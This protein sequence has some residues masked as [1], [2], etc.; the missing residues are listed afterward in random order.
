MHS[1]KNRDLGP[2]SEP[3]AII[4]IGCRFP[5][6]NGQDE[7][8]R[9]LRD[10]IDAITDIPSGRFEVDSVYD[11]LPGAPGKIINRAGGFLKHIDQFDP[12]FFG[13]SP[14][15]ALRLDPQQ[16]LLLEVTWE[17]LED[18]GIKA[19]ALAGTDTCVFIGACTSDYEDIQYHL[20]DRSEIDF[21]VATGTARSLLSGRISYTFDLRGPSLTVDTACSSSLVAVHLAC[22]SLCRGESDLAIAGGVNLVLLPE[23]SMP[24]SRARMLAA[25]SRC[26]FGDAS[27]SGFTRSDGVG[28]VLLKP[29]SKAKADQDPIYAVILSTAT[30]N[31]GRSSGLLATPSRDGQRAVLREAYRKAGISPGTV[32]YVEVHGTGT[33]VGDP[34]E[35]Q[36]LGAV[37]AEGRPA[38]SPCILGSV[39]TNIGHAE[40]AAGIA[41]LIKTAL[42]LKH[43]AIPPS[44]HFKNPNP[45]IPW[46]EL[47][48]VV[49]RELIPWPT[50]RGPAVA[51][52]SAFGLSA[53]NSHI[54]LQEA[55]ESHAC[56]P[57]GSDSDRRAHVLT[58]SAH[59]PMAL[60]A[61]AEAYAAFS[62]VSR[63]ALRDIC[64]SASVR[65]THH[66]YRLAVAVCSREELGDDL[67]AF[68]DKEVRP[69]LAWS[70]KSPDSERKLVFVFPGQGSQWLGMGCQL[71]QQ[72]LVFRSAL[73][74]CDE[75]FRRYVD[76]SLIQQLTAEPGKSR[77]SEIDFVQPCLF[78]IQVA[79]AHLW[80]HWGIEPNAV[81]GQSMGE[82]AAAHVA[83][84]LSLDDAA[85]II[86]RRSSLLKRMSGRGGMAVIGLSF[87]ESQ[88]ALAGY[89]D[90]LSIAVSSGATSTVIAGN[91][92]AL[93]EVAQALQRRGVFCQEVKVDVASHSPQ[94]DPLR[95]D[96]LEALGGINPKAGHIPI[97]ST[98][99]GDAAGDVILDA[100]YWTANLRKPV[101]FSKAVQR[102]I[103]NGHNIFLELSPHPILSSPIQQALRQLGREARVLPSL[104]HDEDERTV[105]LGSLGA[106]YA[107]G[108]PVEWGSLY[109]E[110][111]HLVNLPAYKWQRE[112]FWRGPELSAN[113]RLKKAPDHLL[114]VTGLQSAAD[115]ETYFWEFDLSSEMFPFLKDHCI[116][117]VAVLP[118][119]AYLEMA[120][121][122]GRSLFVDANL[123]LERV[124][125]K[126]VLMLSEE[127][128]RIQLVI[129]S[130]TSGQARFEFFVLEPGQDRHSWTLHATGSMRS[131]Q[132]G[133]AP[134]PVSTEQIKNRSNHLLSKT[135][136]YEWLAE[137]GLEYG[138]CFQGVEEVWTGDK[139]ALATIVL[140]RP[141]ADNAGN[142]H[143]HPA[144]LDSCFQVLAATL[145]TAQSQTYVPVGLGSLRIYKRPGQIVHAYALLQDCTDKTAELLKGDLLVLDEDEQVLLEV[146]GMRMKR[147]D[148]E[149]P[150]SREKR[151]VEGLL[152]KIEWLSSNRSERT[153]DPQDQPGAWVVFI[154]KGGVGT[155]L[156]KCLESS[157]EH[158]VK[159]S[160][161]EYYAK[162]GPAHYQINAGCTQDYAQLFSDVFI[163]QTQRC[164]G[165]VNLWSID[166]AEPGELSLD[167]A[168]NSHGLGWGSALHSVKAL[169]ELVPSHTP[170]LWL[171]TRGVQPVTGY[172]SLSPAQSPIWGLGRAIARE[173]PALRCSLVDLCNAFEQEAISL[174]RELSADGPEDQVAL[175]GD[176][177]YV[178]RLVPYD[179]PDPTHSERVDAP[180]DQPFRL[181]TTIPG[182]LDSLTLRETTRE[183]PGSGDIEI[184]IHAVGLN[185]RDVMLAM[186]VLPSAP[187]VKED[188]GW[189]CAGRVVGIGEGVEGFAIGDDVFAIAHPCFGAYAKTHA[190]LAL[191]KPAHL[192][193]EE[194]ATIPLT[195]LT[196][197]YSL[198]HL[199]NLQEGERVLIHSASGGVGLAAVRIAQQKGADIFAT[200]GSEQKRAF[201][202]SLGIRHVFSSRSLDFVDEIME[203][204]NGEGVDI[205]LNSLTGEAISAGL[206]ILRPG[207]RFM[208]LGRR[209][210]YQGAKL[211]LEPFRKSLSFFAIDLALL[212]RNNP[213]WAGSLLHEAITCF[214]KSTSSP[215]P[216]QLFSMANVADGFRSMA[217]AR[218][219]GKIALLVHGERIKVAPSGKKEFKLRSD[220]TYLITGGLGAL[221]L[222]IARWMIERG[223]RHLVLVARSDGSPSAREAVETM[224]EAAEV[225]VARADVSR[226]KE[227]NR[228]LAHINDCMPPLRGLVHAAGLLDDGILVQQ[229]CSRFNRVMAPKIAGAW[230]LH[231][232]TLNSPLDFFVLF[233]SV[234]ALLGSAGQGNY[235]AA[236]AFLDCLAHYRRS[237]GMPG[238]S[239]NWGPWAEIGLAAKD[240]LGQRLAQK[241]IDSITP[242]EGVSAFERLLRASTAQASVMSFDLEQW[243]RYYPGAASSPFFAEMA[244]SLGT[245]KPA[246]EGKEG[247]VTREALLNA[248]RSER[249]DL[250]QRYLNNLLARVLGFDKTALSRLDP[251]QPIYRFGIDSLMALEVKSR[252]EA[253]LG[254]VIPIV[255][256]L[257]GASIAQM[258]AYALE[259]L[260]ALAPLV[261]CR[262]TK[263]GI[264]VV[265]QWEELS[266]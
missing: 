142:Y 150:E 259:Q 159:V 115:P 143:I 233:S 195:W 18:A 32:Q 98:V 146:R 261:E 155:T 206:S 117:G 114:S 92:E 152:Y 99:I 27:A 100:E 96:L 16:R 158:C 265:E 4:G 72:E 221:G 197:H 212:I 103:E 203:I 181:E 251:N 164:R 38:N 227:V 250:L 248:Q 15:E 45:E 148:Q 134:A 135:L 67:Q 93:L 200:A 80:Q 140:P 234:A 224:R 194:A 34:V 77:L 226:H 170:R 173:H 42:C 161:G 53:T 60:E 186:D 165:V 129:S 83:G 174:W 232:L 29:L 101:L 74:R 84:A 151:R 153:R 79:L 43:K 139:E 106:L 253:D 7:F 166:A 205:V 133:P 217:Q 39:K 175:Q 196:A 73:V 245:M 11:P 216:L 207:G 198:N 177:R 110:G 260:P 230:N 71:M 222:S 59:S 183:K 90:R 263:A 113:D 33:S 26:K 149:R 213:A 189:E 136:Y 249:T 239:I 128:S 162:V 112:H 235:S 242:S 116:Q 10:G 201:L 51:A 20:R 210:I 21:Y 219:I 111:G 244:R 8:W 218:H 168:E 127:T 241:G 63:A 24:F 257:K 86:C 55:P 137:R 176:A 123:I 156:V 23:L 160:A 199:G 187:D 41:G 9:L 184:R 50:G 95:E 228:V 5:G 124:D 31:D 188:F 179:A 17:A 46:H 256:L 54:V 258:T 204:T 119:A 193:F 243:N 30:N 264:G 225:L 85:R 28:V 66:D 12:Y 62:R 191:H 104:R 52:V 252:I 214:E 147:V 266:L 254:I 82:I 58:L 75:A 120:I 13:I 35:V 215:L 209:D 36:S 154:D 2:E 94:M 130:Q 56:T 1:G 70:Q 208:E 178:A 37:L 3:V 102:L 167:L 78:A 69:S 138:P 48:L 76:W 61:M 144:L 49:S 122:A 40:G 105:M 65:R 6:A 237:Q 157:G 169:E 141:V 91:T 163:S 229:D 172:E 240:D 220:G 202:K 89:E 118:A 255:N 121:V 25:D 88:T 109:A 107:A 47:P 182:I 64:Y 171:V 190:S 108:C 247:G 97:Y 126:K 246:A 223:A 180:E 238:L 236:N 87:E 132:V 68:L 57:E 44:L 81:V 192:P 211:S 145:P 14:R 131:A 185:F 231:S 262:R 125:F 22:Q 19:E